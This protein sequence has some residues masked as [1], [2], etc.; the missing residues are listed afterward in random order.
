MESESQSMYEPF[1]VARQPILSRNLKTYGYEL[2]FRQAENSTFAE[3]NDPDLCTMCVATCGFIKALETTDQ[4]KKIFVNFTEKLIIEGHYKALPASVTVIELLE[5]IEVSDRLL[6][7]LITIKQQ[8]YLLAVDDFEGER[9]KDDILNLA[10]IIK[11]DVLNKSHDEIR[12]IFDLIKN[13]KVLKLAEKVDNK[14]D[15]D[16]LHELG[17]DYFQGHFFAHPTHLSGRRIKSSLISNLRVL[18]EINNPDITTNK[19]VEIVNSDPSIAYRLLRLLNSAA[20]GFSMNIDSIRHAI[21]L[22]GTVRLIYWLQ[23]V[24]LSGINNQGKPSELFV[25]ALNR[26]RTLQ[27]LAPYCQCTHSTNDSLFLLGIFSLLHVML[28]TPFTEVIN[29]LPLSE[30]YQAAYI[31]REGEFGSLINLLESIENNDLDM[32]IQTAETLSI[33]TQVIYNAHIFALNWTDNIVNDLI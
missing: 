24:V 29:F 9:N 16:F 22:L 12:S 17:F 10:D 7:E 11:V 3:I 1:Y 18:S 4:S 5:D 21:V 32:L 15:Y 31:K 14:K 23:M 30:K 19:L 2:L 26:G 20:F 6:E 13:K 28:D 8:G 33:D 27:E 25:L